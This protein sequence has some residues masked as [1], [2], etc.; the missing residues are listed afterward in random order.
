MTAEP[1]LWPTS[2]DEARQVQA[3]LRSQVVVEDRLGP[4]RLVAGVDAHEAP[5]TGL[6]WAAVALLRLSD[7]E[8]QESVLACRPTTFPYVPGLLSFREAPAILDA[9]DR[10]SVTPDLLLVDGQGIAH[11]RRFGLACHVGLLAGIPAIGAAK[12]RLVG[13]FS[14]PGAEPGDWSPLTLRGDVIGAVLRTRRGTRPLFVS[15]GHRVGLA[16]ALDHVMRCVS[17]YRLPEPT[18]LAD[19]LSRAHP[20][21]GE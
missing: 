9:L 6:T 11:P 10:L 17:R 5:R 1:P 21:G 16:T 18:R 14:E 12:S 8:L 19:R 7:L 2:L 15:P 13:R 4:V 3:Q 20:M